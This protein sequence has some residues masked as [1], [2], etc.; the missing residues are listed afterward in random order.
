M[1]SHEGS[2]TPTPRGA[3]GVKNPSRVADNEHMTDG[4]LTTLREYLRLCDSLDWW[5]NEAAFLGEK[6]DPA[7]L[8]ADGNVRDDT[9]RAMFD[10]QD[11]AC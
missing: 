11:L 9:W 7:V 3:S 5:L 10:Q 4:E 2:A 1:L 6:H 8:D